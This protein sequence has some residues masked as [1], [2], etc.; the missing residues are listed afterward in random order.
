[1][2]NWFFQQADDNEQTGV[3]LISTDGDTVECAVAGDGGDLGEAT[4]PD[5]SNNPQG[6]ACDATGWPTLDGLAA[7]HAANNP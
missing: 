3:P 4:I 5:L 6:I 1:M 2:A 7:W